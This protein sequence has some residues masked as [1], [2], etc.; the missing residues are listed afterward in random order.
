MV[1]HR[2][3][4]AI[5]V[6]LCGEDNTD[7][8]KARIHVG[9]VLAAQGDFDDALEEFKQATAILEALCKYEAR[10]RAIFSHS[11][12]T[13][14]IEKADIPHV[15]HLINLF[16]RGAP[17]SHRVIVWFLAALFLRW[18]IHNFQKSTCFLVT[19]FKTF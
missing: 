18:T 17:M 4:L 16:K 13:Y 15:D 1:A 5:T 6:G 3:C 19:H 11:S 10:I 8:A 2:Q 14:T 9:L 12:K 7:S